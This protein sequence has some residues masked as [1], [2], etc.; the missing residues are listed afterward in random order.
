MKRFR[1][2][3]L[4]LCGL[5][6]LAAASVAPFAAGAQSCPTQTVNCGGKFRQCTG[7]L[8][9]DR[10]EYSRSCLNCGSTGYDDGGEIA[11]EE[12]PIS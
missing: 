7:T 1:T 10:C 2:R 6:A 8:V 4:A 9:G 5:M 11:P 3:L 12:G